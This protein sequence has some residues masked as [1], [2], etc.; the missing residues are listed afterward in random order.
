MKMKDDHKSAIMNFLKTKAE[1]ETDKDWRK[2]L[3]EV[4]TALD[5]ALSTHAKRLNATTVAST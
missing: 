2:R 5:T 1:S 4:A 3:D